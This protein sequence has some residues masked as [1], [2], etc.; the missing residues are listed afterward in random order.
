ME[1]VQKNSN[2]KCKSVF[3]KYEFVGI[4]TVVFYTRRL[5]AFT[6]VRFNFM[7]SPRNRI[8]VVSMLFWVATPSGRTN[9]LEIHTVSIFM[10]S[11]CESTRRHNPEQQHRH[12]HSREN[13]KSFT[14]ST[15]FFYT[16]CLIQWV[17]DSAAVRRNC[18]LGLKDRPD[19]WECW[20]QLECARAKE[21][22]I[23]L[24]LIA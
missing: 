3:I 9:V 12:L 23:K 5:Q 21:L 6:A 16:L 4:F 14:G 13:L 19:L 7:P 11:T 15:L 24:Y 20:L 10:V 1:Q 18:L 2:I 17:L 8:H 22:I